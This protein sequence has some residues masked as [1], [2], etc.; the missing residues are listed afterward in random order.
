M[1]FSAVSARISVSTSYPS[2]F[3][4]TMSRSTRSG[5]TSRI[6][7]IPVS[8][9]TAQNVSHPSAPS[10]CISNSPR[11]VSSSMMSIFFLSLI[12]TAIISQGHV[13]SHYMTCT[14]CG[15]LAP[16]RSQQNSQG[17]AKV[18]RAF[19]RYGQRNIKRGADTLRAFKPYLPAM[20]IN[21]VLGDKETETR[22]VGSDLRGIVGTEEFVEDTQLLMRG[23]A[24]AVVCYA[25]FYKIA[26][27]RGRHSHG[28]SGSAVEERI[29]DKILQD[30][31]NFFRVGMDIRQLFPRSL[32]HQ[33]DMV[34]FHL[35]RK[36]EQ[37][38]INDILNVDILQVVFHLPRL[39]ARHHEH[40]VD[41]GYRAFIA[42]V[43]FHEQT[44]RSG[45]RFSECLSRTGKRGHL[46]AGKGRGQLL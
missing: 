14:P 38:G 35:T 22:T 25:H 44:W 34:C 26:F 1:S 24:D 21:N 33:C 13:I 7:S 45:G 5:R 16:L 18:P 8:P 20:R 29:F 39:D 4:M 36:I 15:S 43:P 37:C 23:D 40:F 41:E 17:L 46:F 42:F 28:T 30:R 2:F 32:K 19:S 10:L 11:M 3:G 31:A 12:S 6:F 9:S 27:P